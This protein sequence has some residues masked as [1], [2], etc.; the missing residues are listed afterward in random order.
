MSDLERPKSAFSKE[1]MHG[2]KRDF[3]LPAWCRSPFYPLVIIAGTIFIVEAFMMSLLS[4]LPPFSASAGMLID[5]LSLLV[6][7]SPAL[8]FFL[9]RPLVL[10]IAERGRTE[11]AL[12]EKTLHLDSILRSSTKMAIAATDLDFHIIYFNPM[13]EKVFGCGAEEVV[14]KT[15]IEIHAGEKVAPERFEKAMET[16][17]KEGE[18]RY[19]IERQTKEGTRLI[20]SVVSGIWD[21]ESRLTGFV[22]MSQDITERKRD[23]D[24][25]RES[26]D[27]FEKI[28]S[29][30]QDAIVMMDSDGNISYWNPAAERT[31]GFRSE[32]VVGKDL[33][34]FIVHRKHYE[35]FKKGFEGFKLTGSGPVLGK[36][37]EVTALRRDGAEFP[38]EVSF[39]AV[40]IK[41]RWNSIG[42][43][44]DITERKRSEETI[45]HMAYHDHLTGLPNRLLLLDHIN[46]VLA[47]GRRHKIAAAVLL[48]DLDR[49]KNI[50]DSLGYAAG[51]E[52]LKGVA[53]RIKSCTRASDTI[54]RLGGDEFAIL[55]QD[56]NRAEE[57]A[58]V[59]ERIFSIFREPFNIRGHG[60]FITASIGISIYPE[61]GTDAETLLKNAGIAMYGAKKEGRFN[62]MLYTPA[63]NE[64]AVEKLKLENRLRKAIEK[65][66]FMLYYQP[67][68]DINTGAVIGI[69]ALVRWQEPERGVILPGEFIPLAEDTGLIVPIGEFVLRT[70]CAQNKIWQDRKLRP[71]SVAVNLSARQFKQKNFVDKVAG[72]LEETGLDP[73]YLELELT[74][75]VLMEDVE[76]NME[77]LRELKA[78]G[79][80]LTIDDFGTGYS[81]L[82]YLKRMPIDRLK[83]AQSFVRDITVDPD[84][85]AIATTIIRM[86][87]SLKMEVIAEGVEI[88]EQLNLLRKMQCD[89]IQGFLI[90]RPIPSKEV[91]VFLETNRRF[92]TELGG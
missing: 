79:I 67:Q 42:I 2:E 23:E 76:T 66:E 68:V 28:S 63:M 75:S 45:R 22:L 37:L 6:L 19:L 88:V 18:Y 5:S 64:K 71:V 20:E 31:F 69:E 24:A 89:K 14:G 65:N 44:R 73:K 83:I 15:V 55:T 51:D 1:E 78:M 81:S 61:D 32:E 34:S 33:H 86:G 9:F 50:N 54:S 36:T 10:H 87:H 29:S 92:I 90:S 59:A 7:I 30:A 12:A 27:R 77:I 82:E 17:R 25:L 4:I 80:R 48:F 74:E 62:Y 91:E 11:V 38:V 85:L 43:I 21:T 8:Y 41:G 52:L 40:K 47:R 39:S 72:I 13:A 53:E 26:E 56:I 3:T 16:V 35:A 57:T 70:A 58:R 84:D 46:Q 49:F 60:L